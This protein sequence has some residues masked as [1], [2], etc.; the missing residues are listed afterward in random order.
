MS[1]TIGDGVYGLV[2]EVKIESMLDN[3]KGRMIRTTGIFSLCGYAGEFGHTGQ[4]SLAIPSWL[5]A[6]ISALSWK[7]NSIGLVS[8]WPRIADTVVYPPTDSID[9][10]GR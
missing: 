9:Q 8:H 6:T 7:G 4:L 1:V 5:G 3:G 10:S 2:I